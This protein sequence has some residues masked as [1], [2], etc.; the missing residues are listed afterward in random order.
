MR[1]GVDKYLYTAS[2]GRDMPA[3][4]PRHAQQHCV[5]FSVQVCLVLPRSILPGTVL[6]GSFLSF[7]H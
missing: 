1:K 2:E 4:E 5:G 6:K 3:C 7:V